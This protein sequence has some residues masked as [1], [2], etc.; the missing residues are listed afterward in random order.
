MSNSSEVLDKIL[1]IGF[2]YGIES[3]LLISQGK[4]DEVH[5]RLKAFQNTRG[6]RESKEALSQELLKARLLDMKYLYSIRTD[7]IN[8]IAKEIKSH[9]DELTAALK[10]QELQSNE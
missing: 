8:V 10:Q 5:H 9:I 3:D 4:I 1:S 2:L 7:G 6:F